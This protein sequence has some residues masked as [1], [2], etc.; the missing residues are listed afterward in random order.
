MAKV[1]TGKVVIPAN[2]MDQYLEAMQTAEEA[3]APFRQSLEQ[4]N[5]DFAGFLAQK[6]SKKT[7]RKHTNIVE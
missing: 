2:Q 1:Y 4:L 7:V 6:Y 5:R 3:R